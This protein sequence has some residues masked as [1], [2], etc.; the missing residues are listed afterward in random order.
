MFYVVYYV[1]NKFGKV[2]PLQLRILNE[3]IFNENIIPK[4]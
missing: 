2:L 4:V 1:Y 3:K